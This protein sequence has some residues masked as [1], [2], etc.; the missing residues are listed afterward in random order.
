MGQ[1]LKPWIALAVVTGVLAGI[2]WPLAAQQAPPIGKARTAREAAADLEQWL[3]DRRIS[4]SDLVG[5]QGGVAFR[6]R[7]CMKCHENS[8][9]VEGQIL[10][11][12]DKGPFKDFAKDQWLD[13]LAEA[14]KKVAPTL[15]YDFVKTHEKR[16]KLTV[17][18]VHEQ[19]VKQNQ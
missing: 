10:Y 15:Q 17:G 2:V 11:G 14:A 18:E 4:N 6:V 3:F 16:Q 1:A 5:G 12:G 8:A 13:K 19:I 9:G 7:A